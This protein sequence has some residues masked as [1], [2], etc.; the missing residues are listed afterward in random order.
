MKDI[1]KLLN[2]SE[3]GKS[4]ER[5]KKEKDDK[6]KNLINI[7]RNDLKKNNDDIINIFNINLILLSIAIEISKDIEDIEQKEFLEKQYQ[8][9]LI[10]CI[11]S[12]ININP[13]DKNYERIQNILYD[14]LCFGCLF[15]ESKSEKK[16]KE[17]ITNLIEPIIEEINNDL[18]KGGFKNIFGKQKKKITYKNTA[19]FRLF[20]IDPQDEKENDDNKK[21]K[22]KDNL[23]SGVSRVGGPSRLTTSVRITDLNKKNNLMNQEDEDADIMTN[24]NK[25]NSINKSKVFFKFHGDENIITNLFDKTLEQYK[26]NRENHDYRSNI[27]NYY[28]INKSAEDFDFGINVEKMKVKE[29][30]K[31]IIPLVQAQIKQF[32]HNSFLQEKIRKNNYKK[33]KKKLFSWRGFW[34]DRYLFFKHPKY[35]KVKIKNHFTKEMVKPLL[36]PVLDINYY[37]PKFS[38]FNQNNLFNKDN[39]D[40][41]ICLDLDEILNDDSHL[42]INTNKNCKENNNQNNDFKDNSERI[43]MNTYF[44]KINQNDSIHGVKNIYGFNYLECLYKLNY[45]GIWD[46]YNNNSNSNN[47]NNI[48]INIKDFNSNVNANVNVQDKI[49]TDSIK[50]KSSTTSIKKIKSNYKLEPNNKLNLKCCIVK[51]T[52]HIKGIITTENDHFNF[53]YEDYS[54]KSLEEI[55]KE[56]ENDPNFDKDMG[57]CYGSMF[58]SKKKDMDNTSF[59]LKYS[60]IKYMF[61]RFYF[62]KESGLEIYTTTNKSYY[63]N[64]K[65]KE[66]MNKF[67]SYIL[68]NGVNFYFREIKTEKQRI[69]G[70]EKQSMNIKKK[71]IYYIK[72]KMEEW[73]NYKISNLE[74]LMWLNIYGGRSFNDL[75]QYPV[76]PW[77]ISNYE[78]N[79]LQY[80]EDN[81]RELSIPMGMI[82]NKRYEKSSIRK[83]TYEDTYNSL[84]NEFKESHKDFNFE[85]YLQKGDE[86]FESYKKKNKT[87]KKEKNSDNNNDMDTELES[88]QINQIPYFF[89]SHYSNPTY[90]SHYLTRIFPFSFAAIEIQGDKFDDPDRMFFSISKT[91]ESAC[92]L[93]ND[94]RELI[95]EFYLLPEIYLNNNNLDLTQG[96]NDSEGK[97]IDINNVILPPWSENDPS[98]FVTEMRKTLENENKINKWIDLIFGSYQR[99]EK[100]EKA[101]NIFMAQTYEK[102]IKLE[103]I[104]DPDYRDTIMRMIE[105]GVTPY[106]ILFNDSKAR[107]EKTELNQKNSGSSNCKGDFLYDFKNLINIKLVKK[108]EKPFNEEI[109]N[110]K[111]VDNIDNNILKIFTNTNNWY[112]IQFTIQEKKITIDDIK[113]QPY[114]SNSSIYDSSYRINS[115]KN[116][117]FIVYGNTRYIFKGGFWDGRLEF[118]SIPKEK[119]DQK[120]P[121]IAKC[122]FSQY[123]KPIIVMELSDDEK[124]LIC[125]TTNGLIYIY[126]ING[127]VIKNKTNLFIHSEEITSISINTNLNMFASVSKDGYLNLYIMPSFSLVR[128]IKLSTKVKKKKKKKK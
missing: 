39:Y 57:C 37:L 128:A 84:K 9:F 43:S 62:Y 21:D 49:N 64:F 16:Y 27:K 50:K 90:V 38:K 87:K 6:Q 113:I 115:L 111:L 42:Y 77:I 15:L 67:M 1:L 98:N 70:Y 19:V 25:K 11:L 120:E 76:I 63:F 110:I 117:T 13:S 4:E 106:K 60:D 75:T 34:S 86:Y 114:Q 14:V 81:L 95:P 101:H 107:L 20:I 116:N 82:N 80:N 73:Q 61:I 33:I 105:I 54:N 35:L 44:N 51:P 8:Q 66:D 99:G 52:Q 22:D 96:K 36:S 55:Q 17:I 29:K 100:A 97:E 74:Y 124:Y 79:Q 102:M 69:L 46:L 127:P 30:I 59:S 91:F 32:S 118:N 12:S 41:N 85:S 94:V 68:A 123:S 23:I 10:F 71:Q 112:D 65:T 48:Q 89:G 122:I 28:E 83:E 92:T 78:T 3:E 26:K 72:D 126:N 45:D 104:T 2:L 121:P 103:E 47:N 93:N 40:Y 18:K 24:I 31:K 119:K 7:I 56:N 88:F 125:G 53:E 58:K 108:N 5:S 109:I